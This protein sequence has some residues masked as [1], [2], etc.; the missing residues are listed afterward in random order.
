MESKLKAAKF[1]PNGDGVLF[2][3][4]CLEFQSKQGEK[5]NIDRPS[6]EDEDG[7]SALFTDE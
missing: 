3:L 5:F 1:K 2:H 7:E 4:E 6:D